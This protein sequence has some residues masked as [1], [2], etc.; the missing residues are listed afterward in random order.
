MAFWERC[1]LSKFKTFDYIAMYT[2][3]SKAVRGKKE[4][5]FVV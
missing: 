1:S 3:P 4:L 2:F 5:V